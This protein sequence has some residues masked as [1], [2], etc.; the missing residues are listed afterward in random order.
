MGDAREQLAI[1]V[2]SRNGGERLVRSLGAALREPAACR[3]Y[4]D[5]GS[6][7]RSA[8]RARALDA[9]LVVEAL[10]ASAP[11]T[12]AR[13]RNRGFELA[14][15]RI[16]TLAYVQFVDG[17][18]VLTPGWVEAA[19]G[20]FEQH[21]DVGC[22]AGRLREDDPRRNAYHRLADMEW[23]GAL[24][25]VDATGGIAMFRAAAFA[26]AGGFDPRIGAG[27]E[28][29]LAI[30]IRA[31]GLRVVRIATEM[32]R[33]DIAM[34]S[35]RE[36]WRRSVRA[37]HACAEGVHGQGRDVDRKQL[38]KL[39]SM[40]LWGAVIPLAALVLA[41]PSR[42]GSLLLLLGYPV[43]WLRVRRGRRSIPDSDAADASLYA[44]A[45]V[46][47][48]LANAYGVAQL[49]GRWL[50]GEL[51]PVGHARRGR[52]GSSRDCP[53]ASGRMT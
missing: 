21:P 46:A 12:A 53:S 49:A 8:E 18:C 27:E 3:I 51:G 37:G 13:G 2:I 50:R 43:L 30:R 44:S 32:A 6:N 41:L 5:S 25:D 1:I 33:H 42:G 28:L 11:F 31:Q 14:R 29:D 22:V 47:S 39:L 45:A 19:I 35:F 17:D 24:G 34:T 23:N 36:W 15:E 26:A 10:D 38:R 52:S 9:S 40:L 20:H 4:V 7:D 16:P 48:K